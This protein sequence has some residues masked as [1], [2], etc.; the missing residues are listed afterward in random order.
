MKT[1]VIYKELPSKYIFYSCGLKTGKQ[2]G[3]RHLLSYQKGE[4]LKLKN[5]SADSGNGY[6]NTFFCARLSKLLSGFGCV[7]LLY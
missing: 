3:S 5:R 4:C 2:T 1:V 6:L 7:A